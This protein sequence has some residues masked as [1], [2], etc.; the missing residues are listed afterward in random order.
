MI[1]KIVNKT[2]DIIRIE[3][4]SI[5]VEYSNNKNRITNQNIGQHDP[6]IKINIVT[7]FLV[8]NNKLQKE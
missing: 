7:T 4:I 3:K 1:E 8:L 6:S 5:S 2:L